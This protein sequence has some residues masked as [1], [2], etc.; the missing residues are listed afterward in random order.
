MSTSLR[1]TILTAPL[2]PARHDEAVGVL[3][4]DA[5]RRLPGVVVVG[6]GADATKELAERVRS[7]V[8][9][10]DFPR[11]RLV[12]NL[13]PGGVDNPIA[14]YDLPVALAVL[15]LETPAK[16][17]GVAAVGELSLSGDVRPVHG[18]VGRVRALVRS[19]E[20]IFVPQR[21]ADVLVDVLDDAD[22]RKIRPVLTLDEAK[23]VLAD[24]EHRGAC[25][26]WTEPPEPPYHLDPS[27]MAV[28][29]L[30]VLRALAIGAA[31]RIP[32]LGCDA[33]GIV[34]CTRRLPAMLPPPTREEKIRIAETYSAAGL[35]TKREPLLRPFRAPHHTVSE[36]ALRQEMTLA[37][38]EQQGGDGVAGRWFVAVRLPSGV[39]LI[40]RG[41]E[42]EAV[43]AEL[44][45]LTDP[46]PVARSGLVLTHPRRRSDP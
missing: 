43:E 26:T 22:L 32:V 33:T 21:G 19:A 2:E 14:G 16:L 39:E 6:A 34:A 44:R 29:L 7:A 24:P 12:V 36:P 45:R 4:V 15:H 41:A 13:P 17:L 3:T 8:G 10:A 11:K 28:A 25:L 35:L 30:P 20:L 27:D 5:E 42:R 38:Q 18:L 31:L 1:A 40:L 37:R 23:S 46:S 9:S